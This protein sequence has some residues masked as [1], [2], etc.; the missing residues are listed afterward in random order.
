LCYS[1]GV[2][3]RRNYFAGGGV[4]SQQRQRVDCHQ[5][6]SGEKV[7]KSGGELFR[8][9]AAPT[10][11]ARGIKRVRCQHLGSTTFQYLFYFLTSACS[12]AKTYIGAAAVC[13]GYH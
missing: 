6:G 12:A 2:S 7:F 10:G 1:A 11:K 9:G 8:F 5:T 13:P 3:G 4:T